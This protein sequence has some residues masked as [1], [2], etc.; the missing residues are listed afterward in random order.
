M[1]V[2]RAQMVR[3]VVGVHRVVR[4]LEIDVARDVALV[5]H[6]VVVEAGHGR[7]LAAAAAGRRARRPAAVAA[8]GFRLVAAVAVIRSLLAVLLHSFVLCTPVLE[9]YFDLQY[10]KIQPIAS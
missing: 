6:L 2:V 4:V 1:Q 9:P 5:V 8:A 3:R 10:Q 7:R